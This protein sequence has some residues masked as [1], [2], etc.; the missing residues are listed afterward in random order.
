MDIQSL[1]LQVILCVSD[2]LCCTPENEKNPVCISIQ[3]RKDDPF[4]ST[5]NKTCLFLHRTQLCSSCNVEKRE[6]KNGVTATLDS[7]QIYGSDDDTA[8]KIR[9][10]DGTGKLIFRRTEHGDFLPIDKNAQKI[11]CPAEIRSTCL[12]SGDV[13]L[14]QHTALSGIQTIYMREHNRIATKMKELN[15]HWEEERLYQESRRLNIA[16]LQCITYREYL[17]QLLGSSIMKHFNLTVDSSTQGT[18]YDGSLRLG[19]WNEFA[20]SCFRLHSMIASDI[21][22]L[23]MRFRDILINPGLLEDGFM[24]DIMRGGCQ[25]PSEKYDHWHIPDIKQSLGR[26]PGTIE[27]TDLISIDIQR[28][29]DHGMPPYVEMVKYCSNGVIVI[30]SFKDLSPLLMKDENV[31]YLE[32]NFK[33]VQD[34]D[35]YVGIQMEKLYPGSEVGPTTACI[36]AKQFYFFKFADRFYFEHDGEVPSFT[37]AQRNSLKQCSFSRLLCDNTNITQIQRNAMILSNEKNPVV[38]CKEIPAIDITLWKETIPV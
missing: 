15:P 32:N 31:K 30:S 28:A 8:S 33:T 14:N 38:P 18:K 11:F 21:G 24:D 6:Q 2:F 26:T 4:F 35:L 5:Y 37:P 7:S 25:V 29:R 27:G 34:I 19:V 22:A 20:N 12:K 23:H 17:P 1:Y 3:V 13:R 9:A 16:Q 10:S 36:I